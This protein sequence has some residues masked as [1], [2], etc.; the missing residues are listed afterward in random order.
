MLRIR[1]Q[2]TTLCLYGL[3]CDA[4]TCLFVPNTRKGRAEIKEFIEYYGFDDL[5][6]WGV[7]VIR[8]P[9]KEIKSC[10]VMSE[11]GAEKFLA[12]LG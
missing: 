2:R 11:S 5:D 6:K 1:G 3:T 9:Y 12:N 10:H 7:M 4:P 8:L